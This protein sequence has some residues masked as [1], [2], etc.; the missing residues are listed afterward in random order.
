M[1]ARRILVGFVGITLLVLLAST[2]STATFAA[3]KSF[4]IGVSQPNDTH[5]LRRAQYDAIRAYEATHPG[6]K[7]IVTSARLNSEKQASDIEDLIS[8]GVDLIMVCP[9]QSA[10]L[11]PSIRRIAEAK[12]P[13]ISFDR[14][15]APDV[16]DLVVSHI[17]VDYEA[18]GAQAAETIAKLLNGKGKIL[19][20]EGVPGSDSNIERMRGFLAVLE[21]YPDIKILSRQVTN[22]QREQAISVTENLL[23]AYPDA[24]LIF[25]EN[26]E[27]ALGALQVAKSK[28]IKILIGGEDGQKQALKAVMDGDLTFTIKM[29]VMFP[30]AA[31]V[32]LAYLKGEKVPKFVKLPTVVVT[33]DN[34][35]KFY[36]PDSLF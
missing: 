27:M 14:Q 17:G 6:V 21:K 23:Q 13:I 4:L 19:V 18:E 36:D 32:A 8:M 3:K 22:Y 1:L 28:N 33:K 34:V 9:H 16:K 15:L 29:S 5:P 12:I 30:E 20:L 24:D 35:D 2:M 7:F 11:S 31:D 25:A 10:A 26:D